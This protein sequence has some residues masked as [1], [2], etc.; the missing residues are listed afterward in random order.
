MLGLD[1]VIVRHLDAVGAVWVQ[2]HHG[3]AVQP[4]TVAWAVVFDM[5]AD[6]ERRGERVFLF[7]H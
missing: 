2:T 4:T 5:I 6:G 1:R 7:S 3:A